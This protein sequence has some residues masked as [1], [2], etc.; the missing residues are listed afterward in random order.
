METSMSFGGFV[1]LLKLA[2]TN[3]GRKWALNLLREKEDQVLDSLFDLHD[4]G[5]LDTAVLSPE[6][7]SDL[8]DLAVEEAIGALNRWQS[9]DRHIHELV[10]EIVRIGV[11]YGLITSRDAEDPSTKTT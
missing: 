8:V 9:T 3:R 11:R 7:P 5:L 10:R 6:Q 2:D 4:M 1:K